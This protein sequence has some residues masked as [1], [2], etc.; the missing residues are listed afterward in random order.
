MQPPP[1]GQVQVCLEP[2]SRLREEAGSRPLLVLRYSGTG[3]TP[4]PT[5]TDGGMVCGTTSAFSAF[6]LGY[7]VARP[8][9]G[10]GG[11]RGPG[12]AVR[13]ERRA[14]G[15]AS[16]FRRGPCGRARRASRWT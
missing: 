15:G 1:A 5:T 8:G 3:W 4:L 6:V 16:R 14:R 2:T 11:R 9:G 7:E 13:D 12:H 10:G